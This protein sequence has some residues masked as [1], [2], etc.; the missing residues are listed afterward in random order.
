MNERD[1]LKFARMSVTSDRFA[2]V[3]DRRYSLLL[4]MP[5]YGHV[6]RSDVIDCAE[7]IEIMGTLAPSRASPRKKE[8]QTLLNNKSF[9]LLTV[10]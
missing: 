3:C 6:D 9:H 5:T 4:I 1:E 7:A 10:Q 2:Y 8:N